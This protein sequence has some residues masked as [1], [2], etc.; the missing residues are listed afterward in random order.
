MA[1]HAIRTENIIKNKFC[2]IDLSHNR[3]KLKTKLSGD[4]NKQ[5]MSEVMLDRYQARTSEVQLL[6]RKEL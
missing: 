4:N 1:L 2:L 3:Y 5:E 6:T